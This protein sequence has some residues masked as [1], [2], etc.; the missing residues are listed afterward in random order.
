MMASHYRFRNGLFLA[1]SSTT[2]KEMATLE[3]TTDL[4]RSSTP[5]IARAQALLDFSHFDKPK[6]GE[7]IG[8][9]LGDIHHGVGCKP[10]YINSHTVDGASNAEASVDTL[11]W[12][13]SE[14][15][16][17]KIIADKCDAHK[18]STTADQASGVSG[19]VRN[20]N[21]SMG[22]C[23]NLLHYWL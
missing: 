16:S 8:R 14:A 4:L 23:L 6:T 5:T 13:T 17:Q 1:V 20:L 12:E 9:W 10:D 7:N 19:H 2:M 18:I 21:P 11:V 15:R 3:K 22:T